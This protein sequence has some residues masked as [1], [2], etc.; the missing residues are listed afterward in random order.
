MPRRLLSMRRR[1]GRSSS[2]CVRARHQILPTT[3]LCASDHSSSAINTWIKLLSRYQ[4][5]LVRFE[6]SRRRSYWPHAPLDPRRSPGGR[7]TTVPTPLSFI[8]AWLQIR[9][10]RWPDGLSH[11]L[12]CIGGRTTSHHLAFP[13]LQIW[14]FCLLFTSDLILSYFEIYID[15]Y[16]WRIK[17]IENN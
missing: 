15:N 9:I 13:S 12:F 4:P 3:L 11:P 8:L 7:H 6:V 5:S 10:E 1:K 17:D 16:L 2:P 14:C